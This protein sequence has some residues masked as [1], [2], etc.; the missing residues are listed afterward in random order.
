MDYAVYCQDLRSLTRNVRI[1]SRLLT[2]RPL[3]GAVKHG[4]AK[5]KCSWK[6]GRGTATNR[7]HEE[8]TCKAQERRTSGTKQDRDV[9]NP[10]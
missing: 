8:M 7:R 3:A 10:F 2:H 5:Q 4:L 1:P 9:D 6:H